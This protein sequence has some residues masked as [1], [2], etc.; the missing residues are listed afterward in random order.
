MNEQNINISTVLSIIQIINNKFYDIYENYQKNILNINN[1]YVE[2]PYDYYLNGHC[3][4]YSK[5]LCNIFKEYSIKYYS[6]NHIITKIGDCFYDVAGLIE[7]TQLKYYHKIND[8]YDEEYYINTLFNNSDEL[9]KYLEKN[10]IEF[11]LK[12]INKLNSNKVL[13]KK[14]TYL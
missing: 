11:G 2:D 5:I 9:E 14:P 13:I 3:A 8:N 10:L 6:S 12:Q 1:T 7:P 4:S